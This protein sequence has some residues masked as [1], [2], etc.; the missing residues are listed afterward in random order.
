MLL[1]KRLEVLFSIHV[2]IFICLTLS[3]LSFVLK[4]VFQALDCP[5]GWDG[6]G[7]SCY[8]FVVR[9]SSMQGRNW[10]NASRDCLGYGGYLVSIASQSEMSFIYNRSS[11]VWNEH[12]WIGLNDRRNESQF[13]WS[14]GTPY[15][16]SVYSNWYPGE[17]NDN[18]GAEDCV[19]LYRTSWN[20]NGCEGEY[21]YICEKNKPK[22]NLEMHIIDI[23]ASWPRV[24]RYLV[25]TVG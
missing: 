14:D 4:F 13:V 12:Y 18:G 6:Y 5:S 1:Q 8:K 23:V 10:E 11:K 7:N 17:P 22:G 21:G 20:D 16:A 9:S 3:K 25:D 2:L 24:Q 15:N 19:E